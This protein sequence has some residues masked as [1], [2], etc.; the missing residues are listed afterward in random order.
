[1]S[2]LDALIERAKNDPRTVVLPESGDQRTLTAAEEILK[3]GIAKLI[4]VGNREEILSRAGSLD[5]TGAQ[6]SDPARSADFDTFALTL[7]ELRK[8]K[9]MTKQEAQKLM[10]DPVFWAVMLVKTGQ[11]DGMVSGAAHST[12][13]TVRPALQIVRAA[14]GTSLV[15]SFFLMEVPDCSYGEDGVFVM[16][17][18]ALN[19]N[20]DEQQ[21]AEIALSSAD[22]FRRMVGK[23]PKVG[24]LSY[25]TMGSGSGPD[26]DKV[27]R[28]V[29]IARE[30]S[31]ELLIDGEMQAD[32]A[33]VPEVGA[34]KAP[35]SKVA[36]Q[37]NV[38]V[39]PDLGSANIGYKLV[40]RLAGAQAYGPI[41]Q[42]L[43]KPVND[44]SRGCSAADIVGV[45]A[46][47]A[48]QAQSRAG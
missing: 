46:I 32:A 29:K 15:S 16:A 45:A 2:L 40:Q 34:F 24:M 1:M 8:T 38:L 19:R 37:A 27:V 33:L 22:T 23:E 28:A 12:A 7:Y 3:K 18:C 9:G 11:A 48:V 47:T 35:G 26:V 44:L 20:P 43:A 21:L 41:L 31:P 39:F 25:S 6:F 10:T 36:G 5:L 13:D 4:L 42:G 14:S 30:K 17:D